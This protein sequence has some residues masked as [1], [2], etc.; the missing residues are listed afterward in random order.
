MMSS[1]LSPQ[2]ASKS[3]REAGI[4]HLDSGQSVSARIRVVSSGS[5]A[6]SGVDISKAER[7]VCVGRGIGEQENIE[8]A[9]ALAAA[10]DAELAASRPLVD[11]GW[12]EKA[13]QVGKSGRTVKP[14]LYIALGV[15]GAPEHLEGMRNAGTVIAVNS[16]PAAPIFDVAHWGTTCDVVELLPLLT[17]KL[18]AAKS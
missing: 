8:L 3:E 4:L 9:R 2:T 7:I 17:K 16:N 12:V 5:V 1:D 15:S 10:L 6:G 11:L 13:R 18:Q 14:K